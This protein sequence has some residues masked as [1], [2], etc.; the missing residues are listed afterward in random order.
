M[1]FCF[2]VVIIH[3]VPILC[4]PNHRGPIFPHLGGFSAQT[5][6][7]FRLVSLH[8]GGR[9]NILIEQG[10][11]PTIFHSIGVYKA[12]PEGSTDQQDHVS[13]QL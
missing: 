9:K 6:D 11:H 10:F 2:Q 8:P 5:E 12:W 13:E 3:G 1:L 4:H 7:V